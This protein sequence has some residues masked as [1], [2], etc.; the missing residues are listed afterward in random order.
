[1][2]FRSNEQGTYRVEVYLSNSPGVPPVPWI[3]T[4][5]IYMRPESWGTLIPSPVPTTTDARSIQGGPWHTEKDDASAARVVQRDPPGGGV[6]FTYE[7]A[8]GAR[9]GQYAALGI[10]VGHALVDRTHVRFRAHASQPMRIS[11]QARRPRSGERWQRSVYFDAESREVVVALGDMR[12]VDSGGRF[13]PRLVDT[14][15]FV[16]D[17]VNTMPGTSGSFSISDLRVE[18]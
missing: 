9:S 14:V 8:A 17:T 7:L 3:V 15:L 11:V 2:K 16:V 5:A 18:R 4:N 1:L 13:D 12:S 6:E 10:S